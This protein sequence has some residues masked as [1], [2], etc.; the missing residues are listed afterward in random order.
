MPRLIAQ[1]GPAT[2]AAQRISA[3]A[4]QEDA[5]VQLVLLFLQ[6]LEE[7]AHS[8]PLSVAFQNELPLLFFEVRPG[9]VQRNSRQ[10]RNP[11][12]LRAQRPVLGL[13]P[14]LHCAFGQRFGRVGNHQVHVEVDGVAKALAAR[15]GAI[16]IVE[17]EQTRFGM[18]EPEIATLAFEAVGKAQLLRFA[19]GRS[20]FKNHFS[21]LAVSALHRIHNAGAGL[22]IH[23]NA[24]EQNEHGP[25]EIN[26]QQRFRSGELEQ[27]ARLQQ[28]IE[29]A[30]AQ[31]EEALAQRRAGVGLGLLLAPSARLLFRGLLRSCGGG[32]FQVQQRK[33]RLHARAVSERQDAFGHLVHGVV[34]HLF[35]AL[36]A[37]GSADARIQQPQIVVDLGGRGNR[38]AGIA[39]L[40]LLADGDRRGDAVDQIYVR[41]LDALQELARVGRERLDIA[42]LPFGI[43]GV[44]GQR[45]LSA[46]RNSGHHRQAIVR[47]LEVDVLQVVNPRAANYDRI[48]G[49]REDGRPPIAPLYPMASIWQRPNLSI[50]YSCPASRAG[51]MEC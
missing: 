21:G 29:S 24:I 4:A 5:H 18:L 30:L 14:R 40:V 7:A 31:L 46:S 27:F 16:G 20:R 9:H 23:H 6:M 17:G 47:N 45:R 43:D 28:P 38:G 51:S 19:L 8:E 32:G 50:I 35:A 2:G 13:G 39:G 37:V 49:H 22:R 12:H 41:L 25:V 26:P 3:I 11:A 10:A 42:P 1:P 33:E 36:R 44:K 48:L 34:L 15:A